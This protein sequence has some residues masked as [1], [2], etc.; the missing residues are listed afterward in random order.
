[1]AT[2]RSLAPRHARTRLWTVGLP[3]ACIALG[4]LAG[5]YG[6]SSQLEVERR[7]VEDG[8]MPEALHPSD[9]RMLIADFV[10][11]TKS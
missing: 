3:L 5:R 10:P 11:R 2:R 6:L 9:H 8:L 7:L 1:V 4:A